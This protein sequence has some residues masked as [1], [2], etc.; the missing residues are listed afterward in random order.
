[1]IR[2]HSVGSY[3]VEVV[4]RLSVEC[5]GMG[6]SSVS[7]GFESGSDDVFGFLF[8][9]IDEGTSGAGS[10]FGA[11]GARGGG[12]LCSI[13]SRFCASAKRCSIAIRRAAMAFSDFD[14]FLPGLGFWSSSAMF[15]RMVG[16]GG[17]GETYSMK[18]SRM[19]TIL[20]SFFLL[21]VAAGCDSIELPHVFSGNEVPPEVM[22][23][24]RVVETPAPGAVQTAPW[25]RLGDVPSKPGDFTSDA[26]I[27]QTKQEMMND[28]NDAER[29]KQAADNPL[30]PPT[31]P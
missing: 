24:P 25:M 7:A 21:M 8:S 18:L 9:A 20:A 28:R 13:S 16:F 31:Q 26:L 11:S 30:Q 22:A 5:G 6:G 1:M 15:M 3:I 17:G 10:G 4:S 23:E 2:D 19:K 14:S 12:G 29:L 27:L